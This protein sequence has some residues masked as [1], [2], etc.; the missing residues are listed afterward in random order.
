M[1]YAFTW[2]P[3]KASSNFEKHRISFHAAIQVFDDPL[4]VFLQD[5][6]EDGEPRWQVIGTVKGI[7]VLLV[8]YVS[9]GFDDNTEYIRIISARRA[10]KHE[11]QIYERQ[12]G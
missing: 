5:R 11:R 12:D 3:R 4:A 7:E 9:K 10:D 2:D 1:D 8:A 6:I